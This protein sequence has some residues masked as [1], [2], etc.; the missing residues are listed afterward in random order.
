M[1]IFSLTPSRVYKFAPRVR[2]LSRQNMLVI[3]HLKTGRSVR[4]SNTAQCLI[5]PLT[6]GATFTELVST[7]NE[8]HPNASNIEGL[9]E[10]FLK[11]LVQA[12]LF[13]DGTNEVREKGK[14]A[15]GSPDKF[16]RLLSKVTNSV[17]A[18]L[19]HFM[20]F[21]VTMLSI[22]AIYYVFSTNSIP[23]L[24]SIIFGLD[25]LGAIF[26]VV[27]VVPIHELSHALACR[28]AGAQVGEFGIIMHGRVIPGPYVDTSNGY[29]VES[30][31]KRASIPLAG[32]FI[33]LIFAGLA[34][35]AVLYSE[36]FIDMLQ[37][38]PVTSA[39]FQTVFMLALAF[40]YFDTSLLSGSD[41]SHVLE[42]LFDD[43]LLRRVALKQVQSPFS[44]PQA[45]R[46]YQVLAALHLVIGALFFTWWVF[47]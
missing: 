41:G 34:A 35:F 10:R 23:S 30:N 45:V 24:D 18:L 40:V 27:I 38:L 21:F 28:M 7:L 46:I 19:R 37:P 2:A 43:E 16:A 31:W 8:T 20:Y 4:V 17:P 22:G 25:W 39:T 13:S 32:P 3:T 44:Q 5:S 11:P 14:Y 1:T 42:A 9:L 12:G 26:F 29:Q 47:K 33:N 6:Q 15:F 36:A